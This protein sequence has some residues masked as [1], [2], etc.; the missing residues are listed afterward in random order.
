M[1]EK[2]IQHD[3]ATGRISGVNFIERVGIALMR[4]AAF[5]LAPVQF[6]GFR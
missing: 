6:R 2:P 4:I 5:I 3:F 1:S